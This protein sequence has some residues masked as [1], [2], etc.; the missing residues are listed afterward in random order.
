MGTYRDLLWTGA[1]DVVH[2][3]TAR[4]GERG[5]VGYLLH[6]SSDGTWFCECPAKQGTCWHVK[7][8]PKA[9]FYVRQREK[10]R[11]MGDA[12]GAF[13]DE[14]WPRYQ[15]AVKGEQ[16]LGKPCAEW[17]LFF[18]ALLDERNERSA[19]TRKYVGQ[20]REIL[21]ELEEVSE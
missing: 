4:S 16:Y 21:G 8:A 14:W 10:F 9:L 1:L 3:F 20:M 11:Q 2:R 7:E 15:T 13:F 17:E 19:Y 5:Y 6:Q 12:F 18:A